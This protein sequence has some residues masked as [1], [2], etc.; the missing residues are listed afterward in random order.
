MIRFDG[1][2][3][4]LL[5][6]DEV[7]SRKLMQELTKNG[8]QCSM[9]SS[10]AEAKKLFGIYDFDL[11]LSSPELSDGHLKD[12]VEW[13][14]KNIGDTTIFA[15]VSQS[16]ALLTGICEYVDKNKPFPE[17]LKLVNGL[18]FDFVEFERNMSDMSEQNGISFELTVDQNSYCAR[19]LEFDADSLLLGL[20]NTLAPGTIAKLKVTFHDFRHVEVFNLI[21]V[22]GRMTVESQIFVI[23]KNYTKNW[24]EV[25]NFL[26]ERQNKIT[27]FLNKAAGN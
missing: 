24:T 17:F 15:E 8:A 21:G 20:E 27:K 9:S 11:V 14:R 1:N 12:F 19:P 18:L 22:M 6:S 2:R 4:M 10:F 16:P 3:I 13:Y 26:S 25:M 7:G 23:D 5:D